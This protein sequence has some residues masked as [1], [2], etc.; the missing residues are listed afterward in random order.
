MC[1]RPALASGKE[2]YQLF[3]FHSNGSDA[4]SLPDWVVS[5]EAKR[6]RAQACP[7]Q[8]VGSAS[9][10]SSY[11]SPPSG[12]GLPSLGFVTAG[13]DGSQGTLLDVNVTSGT[14]YK[15]ALYMVSSVKPQASSTWSATRQ[16]IRVMDLASLN[17]I[18]PDGYME[19]FEGGLYWVLQ[20]N[21]GV[22]LRVMPIDSDAGFSAV[23]FDKC[24]PA[25]EGCAVPPSPFGN[26]MRAANVERKSRSITVASR[27]LR[28]A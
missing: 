5:V 1:L 9:G 16:A 6:G 8:F 21:R 14:P 26:S 17:P 4:V 3:G 10:N 13:A 2:G 22:R 28:V 18:A 24:T 20:Y 19:H 12:T 25:S 23:F 7:S 11:L 27:A 15:L